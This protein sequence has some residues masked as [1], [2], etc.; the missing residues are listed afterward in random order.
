MIRF[1][2]LCFIIDSNAFLPVKA[3]TRSR[4]GLKAR[5]EI[6]LDTRS[7]SDTMNEE[8]VS[9]CDTII[10]DAEA[11]IKVVDGRL[12]DQGKLIGKVIDASTAEGQD[13]GLA[14]IGSVEWVLAEAQ[15]WKMIPAENLIVAAKNGGTKLAFCVDR[16]EDI[17]GLSR[18]L[19]LGVD[20][21]CI[22]ADVSNPFFASVLAAKEER[23]SN[24]NAP[25]EVP[26]PQIIR[27]TCH[28][29]AKKAVLADRVCV[30][31]VQTLK[32]EEGCWI[33]SSAKLTALILSE[34]ATS[35]LVPSRAFRVNAGPV[36]SYILMGDGK[37]TK[38]LCELEAGDEVCVY[39]SITTESKSV[40]VGRL[41]VEVRPCLIV[42]LEAPDGATSQV[43][44]QQ[45]E[46]VRLGD[47]GGNCIRAT[48]LSP[49]QETRV[50]LRSTT[51]GTHIG[52]AYSGKVVEK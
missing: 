3:P 8:L 22:K 28:R 2:W 49:E 25:A 17:I 40:A 14:A 32:E 43:F 31:V 6:W 20:A 46:T 30:D 18:A 36:H 1:L 38:Y 47:E 51:A 24:L 29:I 44:L 10:G 35:T 34:A 27:G 52:Q 21:L 16:E 4:L 39:N 50:L 19:E 48:D 26:E 15:E 7:A 23:A 33:G 11:N 12:M 42:G 45:A 13:E 41:K 9:Q 37:T 5:M